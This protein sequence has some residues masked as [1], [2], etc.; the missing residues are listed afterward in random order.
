MAP[1]PLGPA[2]QYPWRSW[3]GLEGLALGLVGLMG[4]LIAALA[5]FPRPAANTVATESPTAAA[6]PS[7]GGGAGG[8]MYDSSLGDIEFSG[9]DVSPCSGRSKCS[10]PDQDIQI[11]QCTSQQQ[12]QQGHHPSLSASLVQHQQQQQ[13]QFKAGDQT[14]SAAAAATDAHGAPA[15]GFGCSSGSSSTREAVVPSALFV[16]ALGLLLVLLLEP[17]AWAGLKVCRPPCHRACGVGLLTN[18][19]FIRDYW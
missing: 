10:N 12:Q 1:G 9:G 2:G 4:L 14:A 3:G 15:C 18:G 17:K 7:G 6:A 16:I 11:E 13:H 19:I 8:A 5:K